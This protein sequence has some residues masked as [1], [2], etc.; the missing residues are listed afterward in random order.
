MIVAPYSYPD[1]GAA[2]SLKPGNQMVLVAWHH[3]QSCAQPNLAVAY[4]FVAKYRYPSSSGQKY[5]G[6]APEPTLGI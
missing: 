4:D 2:G 5:A 1:D 3:M 6:E